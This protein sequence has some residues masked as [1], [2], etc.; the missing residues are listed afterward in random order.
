M[1]NY[2]RDL[3]RSRARVS[4]RAAPSTVSAVLSRLS[5]CVLIVLTVLSATSCRSTRAVAEK[6]SASN[7]QTAAD[8]T[9]RLVRAV[10]QES[11]K[12]DTATLTIAADSLKQL[13]E[14]A[15]YVQRSGRAQVSVGKQRGTDGRAVLVVNASCDS[16]ERLCAL[17]EQ[18]LSQGR[19]GCVS[20]SSSETKEEAEHRPN[21]IITSL[22]WLLVGLLAGWI[23]GMIKAT[24]K[25]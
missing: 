20:Q 11:V 14:G 12:A 9:Q 2:L 1:T 19:Q 5:K 3:I 4:V 21:G 6:S 24:I 15:R 23:L 17:Y 25:K 16:L 18:Q 7:V 10:W 13:P 22:K 8:S